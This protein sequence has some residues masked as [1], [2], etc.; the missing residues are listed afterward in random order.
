MKPFRM[1][2]FDE[3]VLYT[4]FDSCVTIDLMVS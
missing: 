4:S 2:L 3:T 1:Y